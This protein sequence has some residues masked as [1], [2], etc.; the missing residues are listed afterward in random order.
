MCPRQF[1]GLLESL[2][3]D[4]TC[5]ILIID[6]TNPLSRFMTIRSSSVPSGKVNKFEV[7]SS[8]LTR[9]FSHEIQ[10]IK[11]KPIND[12]FSEKFFIGPQEFSDLRPCELLSSQQDCMMICVCSSAGEEKCLLFFESG[13]SSTP[14]SSSFI[15]TFIFV[16]TSL[17]FSFCSSREMSTFRSLMSLG[18]TYSSGEASSLIIRY[19]FLCRTGVASFFHVTVYS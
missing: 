6:Q 5:Q 10:P 3:P 17:N 19:R 7:S 15:L 12:H 13:S 2:R 1:G 16:L 14:P 11:K 18:E 9:L 8:K 4:Y